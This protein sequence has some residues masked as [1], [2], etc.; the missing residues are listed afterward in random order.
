MK[1]GIVLGMSGLVAAA[2]AGDLAIT[3]LTSDGSLTW[4]NSVTNAT[5]RVEWTSTAQGPWQRFDALTNLSSVTATSRL[6]TVQ[7][8]MLYRVVWLDAPQHAG[9]YQYSGYEGWGGLVITGLITLS[10]QTN[11]VTGNWSLRQVG[12][13][14]GP[15]GPQIGEG[16]LRGSLSGSQLAAD[17]NPG[18]AD[19]N[20]FL[21]GQLTGNTWTGLW[22]YSTFGG[23]VN[24]GPFTAEKVV[25][26][27]SR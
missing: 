2:W 7:V 21:N 17:L 15:I 25:A 11:P 13:P 26:G 10:A 8:P 24:G 4:T 3:S 5:Y 27:G 9:T 16:E 20:V 19:N 14:I 22:S 23:A 12:E 6:V 1:L 18:W